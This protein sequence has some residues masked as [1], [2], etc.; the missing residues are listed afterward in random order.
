MIPT[1]NHTPEPL[2]QWQR[3][4]RVGFAPSLS[5]DGLTA[6]AFALWDDDQRL[7]QGSTTNP[8]PLQCVECLPCEGACA[9][10]FCGWQGEHLETVRGPQ[11]WVFSVEQELPLF[12]QRGLAAKVAG[13]EARAE[14]ASVEAFELAL[15]AEVRRKAA[16]LRYL[17]LAIELRRAPGPRIKRY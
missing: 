7:L 10:S 6:L 2:E 5:T 4:W 9:V 16:E 8:P 14:A 13:H 17:D 12:G 1:M 3:V 11:S 15:A